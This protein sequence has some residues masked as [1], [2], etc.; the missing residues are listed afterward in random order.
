VTIYTG[1]VPHK[2]AQQN[3]DA[4][5]K[6]TK[7]IL[8]ATMAKGGTGLSLHDKV[9]DHQTTQINVN[10]PW[11]A[12]GVVQV[13]Q[14]SARYGLKGKSEVQW[15]FANNIPFDRDLVRAAR[16]RNR[17]AGYCPATH[18]DVFVVHRDAPLPIDAR[19]LPAAVEPL[20]QVVGRADRQVQMFA[21]LPE[22]P[23]EDIATGGIGHRGE[24][25]LRDEGRQ[26]V[27]RRVL[28]G[29]EPVHRLR[30]DL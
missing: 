24:L 2:Q 28:Q 12:T 11:T 9:G 17:P 10:L 20:E 8:V 23:I 18:P 22:G 3:L 1:S 14:R 26:S 5:R 4:W 21:G 25:V 16:Q 15:V 30:L 6:G 27:D 19:A 29:A 13:A 7:P